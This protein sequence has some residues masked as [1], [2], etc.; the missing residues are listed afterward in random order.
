MIYDVF[1]SYRRDGGFDT[2]GRI[3]DLLVQEGYTVSYDIETLR[4]GRFDEQLLKRIEQCS[5]FILIVDKNVFLRSLDPNIDPK[6][7]WLRQELAYAL[8]LKKNVIPVML[9]GAGFPKGLPDDIN[10]VRFRQGPKHTNEYFDSFFVKLKSYMHALPRKL[11]AQ[12]APNK[13]FANLKLKSDMDCIFYLD[14]EENARLQAGILLKVPLAAGEYE[15]Q[16]ESVENAADVVEMEFE[17]P[18]KDK[19]LNVKLCDIRNKRLI[20]EA[21]AR[22]AE[23]KSQEEDTPK[24]DEKRGK[25]K[26]TKLKDKE[27]DASCNGEEPG[28]QETKRKVEEDKA[29]VDSGCEFTVKDVSFKM[30][31]VEGDT[32]QMGSDDKDAEGNESPVHQVTLNSYLLGET[33]VTQALWAAVMGEEPSYNGGWVE[34]YGRGGDYPAYRVSWKDCQ[35]FI[36]KLNKLTGK[37]FRLPT[38]A[39]WEFAARGGKQRS[40]YKYAGGNNIDEVAWC[41]LNSGGKVH[42][43]K[44]KKP[45]ALG[46][47]DMSGNVFEWC[48]DWFGDYHS[49]PQTN[50]KGRTSGTHRVLRGGSRGTSAESCRV[51]N[52]SSCAPVNC[53]RNRGLRLALL[54]Q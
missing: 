27:G 28:G 22:A 52:R 53:N 44:R 47:Y 39:E 50:P 19:L 21:A 42:P 45:N 17:M 6:D 46:L 35:E 34:E 12:G 18:E 13:L 15:L 51:S 20:D 41:A 54:L 11:F 48:G 8:Q 7:D 1:I 43:V 23:E 29:L 31:Y 24:S 3:N 33:P 30:I 32:F 36:K 2:A 26:E 16:F 49:S 10:E 37:T 9:P 25:V 40:P 38:E 4:E 14:G 5:D